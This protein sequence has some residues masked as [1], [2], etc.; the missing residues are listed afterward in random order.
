MVDGNDVAVVLVDGNVLRGK[1]TARFGGL[2]C[3]VVDHHEI[4]RSK[5]QEKDKQ[6]DTWLVKQ[7]G[8]CT[9]LV[10]KLCRSRWDQLLDRE[11]DEE[12]TTARIKWDAE[13]ASVALASVLV[14][15]RGLEDESR[16]TD[17]D[18]MAVDYLEEK[19]RRGDLPGD[20]NVER[21][22]YFR[23]ISRT[24]EDIG[25]LR[26]EEILRKDY[27]QWDEKSGDDNDERAVTKLGMSSIVK[28]VRFMSEK[29]VA[30]EQEQSRKDQ[31]HGRISPTLLRNLARFAKDR[32]LC[33]Y[34]IM[35]AYKPESEEFQRELLLMAADSHAGSR[36]ERILELA[37][38][39][40]NE[41]RDKLDLRG[42]SNE[43][44]EELGGQW[45]H[46]DG[47]AEFGSF[48]W[49]IWQQTD[50]GKSRKQVA[51]M[52]RRMLQQIQ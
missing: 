13:L 47:D 40:E 32:R 48:W 31:E 28:S 5:E 52:L 7:V 46:I 22:A 44:R 49:K 25:G 3:G 4:E 8:S 34:A 30:E 35:T 9:S 6:M 33:L 16:A 36:T 45:Q 18:R 42:W 19:I 39:F 20:R 1:L 17:E 12:I 43:N 26:V 23:E 41:N 24:K 27:K 2:V 14:D 11:E 37:R 21:S 51:P 38:K 50:V 29:A 15:T 10:V